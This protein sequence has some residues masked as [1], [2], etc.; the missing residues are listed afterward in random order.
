MANALLYCAL[1]PA[2]AP[3]VKETEKGKM[4]IMYY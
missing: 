2:N 3:A 4:E 1:Q